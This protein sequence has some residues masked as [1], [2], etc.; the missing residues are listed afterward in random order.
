MRAVA[1][2]DG[3]VTGVET[4][5]GPITC[6][7]VVNCAGMWARALAQDNGVAVPLWPVEHFYA[8][9]RPMAG[10]TPELPVLR[11]L[12]GCPISAKLAALSRTPAPEVGRDVDDFAFALSKEDGPEVLAA[13][14]SAFPRS[15]RPR[16]SC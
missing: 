14:R 2:R 13:R 12:D 11:D 16:S 1:V 15:T 5:E 3:V 8:V 7:A 9:T 4:A 6:E 10:V